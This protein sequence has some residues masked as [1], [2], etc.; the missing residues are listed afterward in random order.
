[1]STFE[2]IYDKP[3]G[4]IKEERQRGRDWASITYAK[5]NDMKGLEEFISQQQDLNHWPNMNTE[6][7]FDLVAGVKEIEELTIASEHRNQGAML[8]GDYDNN[9]AVV[10]EDPRTSWQLYREELESKG[11]PEIAVTK[12]EQASLSVLRRLSTDTRNRRP[13]QG[14]VVGNVQSGKTANMAGLMAMA[15]DHGWNMFIVLSGL[16]ENLR[17]QTQERLISD[18][19]HPG[20]INWISL[21]NVKKNAP[22]GQGISEMHFR[23]VKNAHLY[24]CLKNRKRLEDLL[25][26]LQENTAKYQ[27][28]KILIIDDEADQGS[29]NTADVHDTNENNEIERKAINRLI[30]N[31]VNS[32]DK[33]N[34]VMNKTPEAVNYVSYTATP[35]ANFLNEFGE[36]ALYPRDFVKALS[37]TNTYFGPKEI[38][39]IEGVEEFQGMNIVRNIYDGD[40]EEIEALHQGS[41]KLPVSLKES[42]CWFLGAHSSLKLHGYK[43]PL[44]MMVHT[45]QNQ[46]HHTAVA[47]A[48]KNYLLNT[49]TEEIIRECRAVWEKETHKFN[50]RHFQKSYKDYSGDQDKIYQF[51]DFDLFIPNIKKLV[52]DITSIPLDGYGDL[53]Y[54]EHLHLCIDNCSNNGINDEGMHVRLAY[55]SQ[56]K[57]ET[58]DFPPAFIVVG[59]TTLSRGLTMEGLIST[60][61]HR[62]SKQ[63]DTLMQMGRWFGYRLRY[64][65]YPRIWMGQDLQSKFEF[66]ATLEYELRETLSLYS[67]SLVDP[68]EYGP[69]VKNSPGVSWLRITAANRQQSAMHVKM[70]FGGVRPQT[71][72]FDNDKNVLKQNKST[73]EIFL[74]KLEEPEAYKTKYIWKGIPFE[75][76]KEN[77][78]KKMSFHERARVF[79]DHEMPQMLEWVQYMTDNE[80]IGPWNIIVSG[81]KADS[82]TEDIWSLSNGKKVGKVTRTRK[83]SSTEEDTI[84]IGVLRAPSDLYADVDIDHPGL[85]S[86]QKEELRKST[87]STKQEAV[88]KTRRDA[89]LGRTPLLIIYCID[90]DSTARTNDGTIEDADLRRDLKAKE[91]IIGLALMIPELESEDGWGTGALT[92][93]IPQEQIG[94]S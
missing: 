19:N 73:A 10:P 8:T 84:N 24:V 89:D 47:E 87:P 76:I 56:E 1:M 42:L 72:L 61:F 90:Q 23:E 41:I 66:L 28:M 52:K 78:F 75:T 33:Q 9:T 81:K 65:L 14:M 50:L 69:K 3:R 2:V 4:W 48:I 71:I 85:S 6:K 26:A 34:K 18:L 35:Y 51:Q 53:D 31:L 94:D 46:R 36:E 45:S 86:E 49:S 88:M 91:D 16:V 92:I 74:N 67:R 54:H 83:A 79:N 38:F 64:E 20:N 27:Q 17:K 63:A 39:G 15:A 22:I 30:V 44:T 13:V 80:K 62:N 37:T 70:D 68:S 60:F 29:I 77:L 59:G 32:K 82:G 5:R 40:Q 43:K 55:P 11:L 57:L 12:I 25:D 93:N 7:W 58:L 21:E